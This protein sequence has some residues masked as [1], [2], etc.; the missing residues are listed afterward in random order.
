MFRAYLEIGCTLYRL[1]AVLD[2]WG[3]KFF[4]RGMEIPFI[5]VTF[6]TILRDF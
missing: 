6:E 1:I 3:L 5:R 2:R 4:R